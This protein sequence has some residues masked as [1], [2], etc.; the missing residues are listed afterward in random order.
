MLPVVNDWFKPPVFPGDE[1]K[2]RSAYVLHV[3]LAIC[4][5]GIVVYAAL[6]LG[7]IR[8]EIQSLAF[9]I[10]VLPFVAGLLHL[11][12]K[13]FVS[14]SSLLFGLLAWLN[15]TSVVMSCGYGMHGSDL[16][17]KAEP[18]P[19]PRE[20]GEREGPIAQAMGG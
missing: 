11:M 14:L 18:Q 17:R 20:R 15:L 4:L 5:G 13:G 10:P 9:L 6:L 2:T 16:R 7:F 1:S 8:Y 3:I 19:S 12:K